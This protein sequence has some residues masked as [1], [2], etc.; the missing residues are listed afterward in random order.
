MS[1]GRDES[2]F[3]GGQSPPPA[4]DSADLAVDDEWDTFYSD[5]GDPYYHHRASG[6]VSWVLPA[7]TALLVATTTNTTPSP[8]VKGTA[9][10]CSSPAS[11]SVAPETPVPSPPYELRENRWLRPLT[12]VLLTLHMRIASQAMERWMCHTNFDPWV[13]FLPVLLRCCKRIKRGQKQALDRAFNAWFDAWADHVESARG[14]GDVAATEMVANVVPVVADSVAAGRPPVSGGG[15]QFSAERLTTAVETLRSGPVLGGPPLAI[16]T[17]T[18]NRSRD[19]VEGPPVTISP[20]AR[21]RPRS[22]SRSKSRS[23]AGGSS[24]SARWINRLSQA[25]DD[26]FHTRLVLADKLTNFFL[27][28]SPRF[29]R[30][31]QKRALLRWWELVRNARNIEQRNVVIRRLQVKALLKTSQCLLRLQD[32]AVQQAWVYWLHWIS[33]QSMNERKMRRFVQRATGSFRLNQCRLALKQWHAFNNYMR[34]AA[35]IDIIEHVLATVAGGL[36]SQALR[37]WTAYAKEAREYERRR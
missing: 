1:L 22:R 21:N 16:S 6:A 25:R 14:E 30:E 20:I 24:G 9:A 36:C 10:V 33:D 5:T 19:P 18:M 8:A 2:P 34:T 31:V 35:S 7:T 27:R 11:L 28:H 37:T 32:K 15:R 29:E 26:D 17:M 13:R 4:T 23:L 3:D 12:A